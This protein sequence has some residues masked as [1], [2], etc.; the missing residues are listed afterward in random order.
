MKRAGLLTNGG[1][2]CSLNALLMYARDALVDEGFTVYGF[3]GGYRGLIINK[4][5]DITDV[6]IDPHSGGTFLLSLRDSPTPSPDEQLKIDGLDEREKKEKNEWWKGKFD[7][8]LNTLKDNNIDL[9]VVLGGNGTI[10]ATADFAKKIPPKKK[11]KIICLPRTIDNDLDTH[12]KH[13]FQG[14][15]IKTA[16]CPGYPSAA[17]KIVR[18]VRDLRTTSRSTERIF[19]IETMG[20]DAGWLA[21]AASLGWADVVIIPEANL[22]SDDNK[23]KDNRKGLDDKAPQ[24][25]IPIESLFQRVFDKYDEE[26]KKGDNPNVIIAVS[27]GIME[28]CVSVVEKN[29]L[30]GPRKISGASDFINGKL[31]EY[32]EYLKMSGKKQYTVYPNIGKRDDSYSIFEEPEVRSQHTDYSPRMGKPCS[33]DVKLAELLA[34]KKLRMML[35]DGML[36]DEDPVKMLVL[37]RVLAEDELEKEGLNATKAI[38]I[39]E[40]NQKL[41]PVKDYYDTDL[42]TSKKEFDDFLYKIVGKGIETGCKKT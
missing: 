31:K 2:T 23:N 30:Y 10:A 26:Y 34:Y 42:L 27:E 13:Y 39:S 40:V 33:Y 3:E 7:G 5:R 15:V 12:T 35:K 24:K 8:A 36:K 20:R 4:W 41:L 29:P 9:L 21:L 28:N 25:D 14:R 32:L 1:D 17:T 16:L 18:A 37:T 38:D 19:T 6:A 11:I 22:V